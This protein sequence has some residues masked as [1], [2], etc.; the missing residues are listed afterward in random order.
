VAHLT[1][2]GVELDKYPIS[3]GPM[4]KF[5]PDKEVFPDSPAANAWVSREY[6]SEFKCPTAAEV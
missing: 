6:R 5:D 3:L 1:K 2:N 4:L